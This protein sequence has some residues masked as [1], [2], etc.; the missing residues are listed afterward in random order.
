MGSCAFRSSVRRFPLD[1]S[2]YKLDNHSKLHAAFLNV[3]DSLGG[4]AGELAPGSM[5]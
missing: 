1:V 5:C 3:H 2:T 4:I